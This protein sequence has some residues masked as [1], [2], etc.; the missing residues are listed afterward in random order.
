MEV[1]GIPK[2]VAHYRI[3]D[4]LGA[5]GM[6]EVYLAED[7]RLKRRIAIKFL[8]PESV[9]D[10]RAKKRLKREAQAAAKLDHPNICAIHEVAEEEGRSFIVMQ[11]VDGE[12]LESRIQR[13]PLELRETLE[14]ATQVVDALAEA[15]SYGIIHRD[16]KPQNIIITVRGQ[17][18]V[19]DFGLAKL[20]QER[21]VINSEVETQ[22]LI[23]EPGTIEGTVPYMSP[24]Q[25]KG[26]TMDGRS[27]IF[28]FGAVLYE[29]VCGRHPF[30][31][32]SAAGILSAILTKEPAPLVRYAPD[33]P[34]ELQRIVC[35]C[36]AKDRQNRYQ[37]AR[38]L[39][40]DLKNLQQSKGSAVASSL[41]AYAYA[42][43]GNRSEAQRKLDEQK[44]MHEP[45]NPL[46]IAKAYA[47]LGDK[48]Q[49]FEWIERAYE[50]RAFEM[51]F[52][53]V[54][55]GF[56]PLRSDERFKNLLR[57]IGLVP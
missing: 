10:E 21:Q 43:S 12:T 32:E 38:D 2:T 36:L 14:V 48:D 27:D 47:A 24:E 31:A 45:G 34:D 57:Q 44:G 3:L 22:S 53:K 56:D 20:F 55:P 1:T 52:L 41:L 19:L 40:I 15:H 49:A 6:G 18:K 5:G 51:F 54:D 23:T 28:S 50:R 25:V 33:A 35:K 9:A 16:I 11:Y 29:A 8:F 39:L 4:K 26:E 46:L 42:A 17:A 37:N 7:T 30:A 13:R